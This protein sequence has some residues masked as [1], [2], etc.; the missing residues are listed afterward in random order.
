MKTE[1]IGRVTVDSAA[2]TIGVSSATIRNWAKAGHILPVSSRPLRFSEESVLNLKDRIGTESFQKLR[3]RANKSGSANNF[4]PDE[5]AENLELANQI[6]SIASYMK[7]NCLEIEPVIFLAALRLLE[8]QGEVKKTDQGN[9]LDLDSYHSWLRNSVKAV[10]FDWKSSLELPSHDERL[11]TLYKLLAPNG[12]YD[13]LGFLYQSIFREGNKSEQGSYYTPSKL[14]KD[15]LSNIKGPITTFLDPCCG[16]GNY[17]LLAAR[18]FNLLPENIF[19]FDCDSIATN[20]A[21]INVLLEFKEN[22]F[23][24]N[25]YCIDSLSELATGEIFCATNNLIGKIDLIATNPPWG[26]YKN[27]TAKNKFSSKIKSGETF[28]LFLEKSIRILRKGGRLSFILPESILKIRAHSDIREII[29]L[30]TRI[31]NITTLGRQFTGVFTPVIRLDLEKDFP[32]DNWL[33]SVASSNKITKIEQ[34]RFKSNNCFAF[35]IATEQHEEILL[36]KL[37]SVEHITLKNNA[38]WALGIVTGDN[39]KFILEQKQNGAEAIF[40]GSDVLPYHLGEPRSYIHFTPESFQQVAPE[41]FFRAPEKLIYRFIS[42]KLVFAYDDKQ[43]LTLNSANIIIPSIPNMSIKVVLAFLNSSVFQYIFSKKFAT[44][45]ILRG[46]LEKL[47]FPILDQAMH[48]IMD[49]LANDAVSKKSS[50]HKELEALVFEAFRL[51]SSDISKIKQSIE[52]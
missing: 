30:N 21:K 50:A 5:Y 4:V 15:S 7:D 24:P 18:E 20:I 32:S 42:K 28:S 22:D 12:N 34:N 51:S 8:S 13:Y 48:S 29:L 46:D 49:H 14:I 35:D 37:Y 31:L 2:Q 33:V 44:H 1:Q 19:G 43:Q 25:I 17:L 52:K 9:P 41:R 3:T 6:T 26:A 10:I 40:R 36:E 23:Q 38:Q 45:K 27:T 39:K 11:L 16:A 47:P